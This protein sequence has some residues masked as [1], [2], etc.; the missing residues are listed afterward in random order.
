MEPKYREIRNLLAL[1]FT[2]P[3]IIKVIASDA[4]LPLNQINFQQ[5]SLLVW[6]DVMVVATERHNKWSSLSAAIRAH[7]PVIADEIEKIGSADEA[8]GSIDAKGGEQLGAKKH[9]RVAMVL[10]GLLLVLVITWLATSP[11]YEPRRD[12]SYLLIPAQSSWVD[13]GIS[14]GPHEEVCL[15]ASGMV[16]LSLKRLVEGSYRNESY[17]RW[18]GPAGWATENRGRGVPPRMFIR[19]QYRVAPDQTWG[20]LVGVLIGPRDAS[21][22]TLPRRPEAILVGENRVV[23]NESDIARTLFLAVNDVP[24]GTEEVDLQ[25]FLAGRQPDAGVSW[26]HDGE[27]GG[28]TTF[29]EWFR[30]RIATAEDQGNIFFYDNIGQFL[31][32]IQRGRA[33]CDSQRISR[34]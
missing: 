27:D 32:R 2:E 31:V 16:N 10:L 11:A 9:T 29:E 19:K 14:L 4:T 13:T 28:V 26:S 22:T 34:D 17:S 3:T 6:H 25:A 21:L 30:T 20:A 18:T 12:A 33:A 5:S 23:K 7:A 24:L 15:R 8:N 1:S